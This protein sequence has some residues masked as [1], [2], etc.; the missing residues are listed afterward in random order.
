MRCIR[1]ALV[2]AAT[3][4]L[5]LASACQHSM[6][7]ST[8]PSHPE[9]RA[10]KATPPAQNVARTQVEAGVMQHQFLPHPSDPDKKIEVYWMKP[11]GTGPWPLMVYAHGH[12]PGG[13]RP[14]AA[15]SGGWLQKMTKS[16][17]LAVAISTPGYGQSDGPPD[18]SGPCTQTAV[19]EII[20]IFRG[21]PDVQGDRVALYGQSR[22]AIVAGMVATQDPLSALVL[23]VGIY[24]LKMSYEAMRSSTDEMY[25]AIAENIAKEAGTSDQAFRQRS[26]LPIA[27]RIGAP[28]LI[29]TAEHDHPTSENQAR[30]LADALTKRGV[31]V[32]FVDFPGQGH[33]IPRPLLNRE[34]DP[35]LKQ[36]LFRESNSKTENA[37]R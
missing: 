30:R 9:D 11:Q 7:A 34:V 20:R 18:F 23:D 17:A 24:D 5:L 15:V 1:N 6:Q 22:G 27:D 4:Q 31:P 26:V 19:R 12:Q 10:A 8:T 3:V 14:G 36:Y 33:M 28:T 35:F 13:I 25:R 21:R 37:P 29:L 32:K 16:G 2:V